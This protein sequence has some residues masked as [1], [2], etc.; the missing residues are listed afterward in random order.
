MTEGSLLI[1]LLV[2]DVVDG[3]QCNLYGRAI[4]NAYC[5]WTI[6]HRGLATTT[7]YKS[8]QLCGS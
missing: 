5:V 3:G 1:R 7:E 2:G 8:S 6:G 4:R